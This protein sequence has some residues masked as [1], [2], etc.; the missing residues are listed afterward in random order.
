M[1]I[2][3]CGSNEINDLSFILLDVLRTPLSLG[4]AKFC[5]F[6]WNDLNAEKANQDEDPK[7][8]MSSRNMTQSEKTR[9]IRFERLGQMIRPTKEVEIR[10]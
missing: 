8:P 1:K 9:P 7:G 6:L 10:C 5:E 3:V 2:L 4:G